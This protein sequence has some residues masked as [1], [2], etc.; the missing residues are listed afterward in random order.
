[1]SQGTDD[2]GVIAEDGFRYQKIVALYFLIVKKVR[3]IEYEMDGQDFTIINENI[4]RSSLEYIQCKNHSSGS[5]TPSDFFNLILP[6]LWKAFNIALQ[7]YNDK[8]AIYSVLFTNVANSSD[9]QFLIEVC[10]EIRLKGINLDDFERKIQTKT[11]LRK[12]YFKFKNEKDFKDLYR[13]L[14]GLDINYSITEE[15][16]QKQIEHVLYKN[17]IEIT[18]K[19]LFP[20]IGLFSKKTKEIITLSQIED[21]LTIRLDRNNTTTVTFPEYSPEDSSI[22]VSN[23]LKFSQKF[24]VEKNLLTEIELKAE[25]YKE[26]K[27][28]KNLL[29]GKIQASTM[30]EDEKEMYR[31]IIDESIEKCTPLAEDIIEAERALHDSKQK[32]F[33][34]LSSLSSA[35]THIEVGNDEN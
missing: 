28:F 16:L 13:F 9:I 2:G 20:L 18:E 24:S 29:N 11:K 31:K 6:Q 32:L 3:E 4:E 5:I 17:G 8:K 26:T 7:K 33:R 23:F 22:I 15:F 21:I 27:K 10:R 35:Y 30:V 25:I 14:W 12:Y 1:M 19:T 34:T